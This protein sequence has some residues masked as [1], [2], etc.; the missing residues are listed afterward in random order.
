[1]K[2]GKEKFTPGPWKVMGP[3]GRLT[4]PGIDA[5]TNG[6]KRS[7]IICG[8]EEDQCGIVGLEN[9]ALISAAPDMY[10]AL[11]GLLECIDDDIGMDE[12]GDDESVGSEEVNGEVHDMKMTFGTIRRARSAL[13]KARGEA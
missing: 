6:E 5:D 2:D 9:D 11:K 10:A 8:T 7:I 1:M 3:Y 13:A 12:F 4:R